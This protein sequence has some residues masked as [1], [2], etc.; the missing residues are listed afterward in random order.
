MLIKT[1][2]ATRTAQDNRRHA[3]E[4]YDRRAA[5]EQPA[6]RTF[7]DEPPPDS[8]SLAPAGDEY[9]PRGESR[10]P[11]QRSAPREEKRTAPPEDN[12]YGPMEN[13]QTSLEEPDLRGP[14][15]NGA[16]MPESEQSPGSLGPLGDDPGQPDAAEEPPPTNPFMSHESRRPP[17][18]DGASGR[19]PLH[20]SGEQNFGELS[21]LS[22]LGPAL[23]SQKLSGILNWWERT[24]PADSGEP[25]SLTTVLKSVDSTNRKRAIQAYWQARQAAAFYQIFGEAAEQLTPL[26]TAALRTRE[27]AGGSAA[28]LRVQAARQGLQAA[29]L[30]AHVDLLSAQ[31]NLMMASGGSL[32]KAWA[33]PTTVPHA[34]RYRLPPHRESLG[35]AKRW[36]DDLP[37]LEAA[38]QERA[39]AV[40][41]ADSA[42]A[43]AM[44]P[45]HTPAAV[46]QAI[47]RI[48]RQARQSQAFLQTVT[49]YNLAI[50]DFAL[51]TLPP[52]AP[53]DRLMP[54]LI[55]ARNL[56]DGV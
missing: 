23:R 45:A 11:R 49:D 38:V 17:V 32:D 36:A 40:V 13:R 18:D 35:A 24:L 39:A 1:P 20:G 6:E 55:I 15:D 30:D 43:A 41:F 46:S 5:A 52:G 37:P 9:Q 47:D 8:R 44:Q 22:H 19:N 54:R 31:W 50:A 48:Y 27:E 25:T 2:T 7:R 14:H 26:S 21:G 51:E 12:R 53:L 33:M 16:A 29:L 4:S 3:G 56:R 34:G 42:R 10:L 28:M